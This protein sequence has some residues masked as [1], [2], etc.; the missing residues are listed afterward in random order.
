MEIISYISPIVGWCE[1]LGHRF[2]NPKILRSPI[3]PAEASEHCR[4]WLHIMSWRTSRMGTNV[5]RGWINHLNHGWLIV[6]VPPDSD[7]CDSHGHWNATP[8]W[9]TV[10]FLQFP[11]SPGRGSWSSRFTCIQPICWMVEPSL[12]NM[13]F[14]DV[15]SENTY[16]TWVEK[17]STM[18][19]GGSTFSGSVRFA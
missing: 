3:Q 14:T 17:W 1:R 15:N 4:N 18:H 5:N 12:W 13:V 7:R 10:G 16:R 9:K 19:F 11:S 2:T 6:V 8:Q